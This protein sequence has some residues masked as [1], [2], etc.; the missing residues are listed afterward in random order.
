MT[1]WQF[2]IP[3]SSEPLES[4]FMQ[5]PFWVLL[6]NPVA[7]QWSKKIPDNLSPLLRD[8]LTIIYCINCILWTCGWESFSAME[9][10]KLVTFCICEWNFE[11]YLMGLLTDTKHRVRLATKYVFKRIWKFLLHKNYMKRSPAHKLN[12]KEAPVQAWIFSI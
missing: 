9:R 12:C 6:S 1:L 10:A 8:V 3:K 5:Q 11:K 7:H 2:D 4:V